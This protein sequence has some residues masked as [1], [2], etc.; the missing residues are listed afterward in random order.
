MSAQASPHTSDLL[1]R[2]DAFFIKPWRGW[3]VMRDGRGRPL[4]R[5][6]AHG[7]GET[8]RRSATTRQTIS[9]DTGASSTVAW[10]IATDDEEQF[11]AR[12]L[13]SGV[14]ARG[15]QLGNDFEWL[16]PTT[17]K[18]R[19]GPLKARSRV[20]YT[21][22]SPT[23]AFSFAETRWFGVLLSSFVTFYEQI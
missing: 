8:G 4:S 19:L 5:Y 20:I 10:E 13:E 21:L 2:P 3:G 9:F 22:A 12:D 6:S 17:V 7:G 11:W 18:T 23:T 1:F 16:F 14:E 15:R